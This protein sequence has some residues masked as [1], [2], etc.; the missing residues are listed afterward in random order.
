[1]IGIVTGVVL[2]RAALYGMWDI[3]DT[4][5]EIKNYRELKQLMGD[6]IQ[7]SKNVQLSIKQS[8]EHLLMICPS[9][10]GKSRKFFMPNIVNM[11]NAKCSIVCNDPSGE[12]EKSCKSN[13]KIYKLNPFSNDTIGYNPLLCCHSEFEVR[14]IANVILTNGKN[15]S[16]EKSGN[17][18]Q[19]DWVGMATPLFTSYLLMNYHTHQYTFDE[20]IKRICTLPI[21]PIK[22][23]PNVPSIVEDI[24]NSQVESAITELNSFLQVMGA[25]QTLSSIRTVM[26]TCLQVFLDTNLKKIF[27][28]PNLNISK[29]RSEES[30]VYIQIPERHSNYFSPLVATFITQ[31]FDILLDNPN[32]LQIYCL[33]DEWSTCGII[34][35]MKD[36][37]S[38]CRKFRISLNCAVQSLQQ[39]YVLYGELEGKAINELFK[40]LIICSGLRD[41]AEYVSNLLG[42]KEYK[43]NNATQTKQLMTADEIRRL[44]VN[45]ALIICNNK[46]PVIDDMMNCI[47]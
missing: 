42:T 31:M 6:G 4:S 23:K 22:D 20:L 41:S 34:P 7:C 18:N 43:E 21:I 13:K 32:G 12:I 29:L 38:T 33:F 28:K 26:N 10:G 36:L 45:K 24:I 9:G 5:N 44:D 14:K 8:N 15:A 40:T 27:N 30:I 17:G 25:T 35:N 47:A 39:L 46:R 2:C 1:M 16:C 19:Q 37:L 3:N 11:N